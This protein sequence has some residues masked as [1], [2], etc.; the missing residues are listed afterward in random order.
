[1]RDTAGVERNV[2]GIFFV[3]YVRMIRKRKDVDWSRHLSPGDLE[4][5]ARRVEPDAWYPVET[6]E[7]MGLAILHEVAGGDM[8]V[9][10]HWGRYY[11]DGLFDVHDTLIVQ[12]DPQ[13]SLMRF[14][15]LRKS[16]FDFDALQLDGFMGAEVSLTIQFGMSDLAE[17]ASVH[18]TLGF[19]ERLLELSGAET[20]TH[21]IVQR[22]WEG[23]PSTI[24]HLEW[25]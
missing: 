12:G 1:M 4:I 18:Q 6:F 16:F 19:F 25:S 7:R 11:M 24:I 22:S 10:H 15:M 8:E 17:Q 5:L 3:D 9:V 21:E 2:K 13:E 23:A 20:V 14:H